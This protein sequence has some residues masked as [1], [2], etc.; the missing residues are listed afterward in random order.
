MNNKKKHAPQSNPIYPTH[1][2]NGFQWNAPMNSRIFFIFIKQK[3]VTRQNSN[4][5]DRI[6]E[7]QM[8]FTCVLNAKKK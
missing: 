5:S 8:V 4:I 1:H 2:T 6:I 3:F 7:T